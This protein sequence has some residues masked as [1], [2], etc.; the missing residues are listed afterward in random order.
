VSGP[1]VRV[2]WRDSGTSPSLPQ[3]LPE[4]VR[5]SKRKAGI[6]ALETPN[7][8]EGSHAWKIKIDN[9]K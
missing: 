2:T 8:S 9:G 6:P 1:I 7:G 3:V 4:T 5:Y